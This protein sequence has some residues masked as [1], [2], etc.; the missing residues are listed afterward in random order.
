V[1]NR[2][3]RFAASRPERVANLLVQTPRHGPPLGKPVAVRIQADD[4]GVAK[5]IAAEIKAELASVPGVFNIEDNVPEGRLELQIALDEH[6]ASLH[7]LTFE[8][9]AVALRAANDGLVPSTFKDPSSDEDVDIR[10]LLEPSQRAQMADLLDVEVRAPQ[11]YRVELGEVA[12]L[13]LSRG[14]QRLYHYD[15]R[16]SVVVYADVDERNATSEAVNA[17]LESRFADIPERFAGV[18]LVFGGEAEQTRQTFDDA[19][20]ALGVALLAIY[21]I[22]ATLFRSYLQPLVVMS[23]VAFAFIGVFL[24]LFV[25]GG[26][27]SM[28][29]LYAGVGLAGIVVNDSL[30]LLDFVNKERARGASLD[31]AVRNASFRRF[32]PILLTTLTTIAG[33]LPMALGL[34]GKSLVFGPFATAIVFGLLVASGLT[35]FVVPALYLSFEDVHARLGAHRRR[36][37]LP[38]AAD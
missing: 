29:V 34:T 21:A 17:D 15:A 7:G 19:R 20:R 9:V 8:D 23:V 16:R 14:Y 30:V 5:R 12:R 24:G 31:E 2:L 3:E 26:A 35:L 25:T 6:R 32:R 37:A 10:V 22:L 1:R 38:P 11:G 4:Y 18:N 27:I 36:P 13:D 33:L 28:W